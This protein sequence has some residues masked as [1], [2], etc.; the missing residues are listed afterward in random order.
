MLC[1]LCHVNFISLLE[2]KWSVVLVDVYRK[3]ERH[4]SNGP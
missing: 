3:K 4:D 2:S 1:I